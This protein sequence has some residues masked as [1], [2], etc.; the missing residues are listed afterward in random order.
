MEGGEQA[1]PLDVGDLLDS[2][3]DERSPGDAMDAG[4]AP[5]DAGLL[6]RSMRP[7]RRR[8]TVTL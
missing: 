5:D 1:E 8:V 4:Q 7:V 6:R 2:D 3:D